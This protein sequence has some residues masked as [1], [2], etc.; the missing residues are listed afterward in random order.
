[1]IESYTREPESGSEAQ[2]SEA[3]V[4]LVNQTFDQLIIIRRQQGDVTEG[5]AALKAAMAYADARLSEQPAH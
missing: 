2:P 4:A 5:I 3:E 1:M